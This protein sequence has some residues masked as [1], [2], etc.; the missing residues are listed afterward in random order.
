MIAA[1]VAAA[2]VMSFGAG[3][4]FA[5]PE[6]QG[7]VTAPPSAGPG[8]GGVTP[9]PEPAP[10]APVE[11]APV[12]DS[13]PGSVPDPVWD[14][15][16][17]P[18]VQ[19]WDEPAP[20]YPQVYNPVPQGPIHLPKQ[21]KPVTPVLPRPGYVMLGNKTGPQPDWLSDP[22]TRSWNRWNAKWTADIATTLISIGVPEDE[23]SRQAAATM[24]GIVAGSVTG[25]ML[26]GPL[27]AVVFGATGALIGLGIGTAVAPFVPPFTPVAPLI[28][29]AAGGAAGAAG[30]LLIVGGAGAIAGG[31]AGG[32][33]GWL[34][35]AGD[36]GASKDAPPAP[37]TPESELS[38][39]EPP[40]PEANQ[41]E[42]NADGLPGNG[43]VSYVVNSAGDVSGSV[44]VGPVSVPL[45]WSAEQADAPYEAIGFLAQT[46]RDTVADVTA[47][48]STQIEQV[49]PGVRV[50]FPQFAPADK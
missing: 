9:T 13:G 33:L 31:V 8:Q 48:V 23:A 39:P 1:A 45:E 32:L 16:A 44:D 36:P 43:T 11:T 30:G 27:A 14:P 24:V 10:T 38:H 37:G 49:I 41:F 50:E 25:F 5:D 42:L 2:A 35:G 21:T 6:G 20:V 29:A 12:V 40:N 28:G 18:V 19:G 26:T 46:A 17:P 7:G 3:T 22:D 34:F 15:A 47:Q 4:A